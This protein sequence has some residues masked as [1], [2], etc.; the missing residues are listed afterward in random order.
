MS[1]RGPTGRLVLFLCLSAQGWEKK[2]RTRSGMSE[3]QVLVS[4]RTDY[5]KQLVAPLAVLYLA[6]LLSRTTMTSYLHTWEQK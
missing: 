5:A 2:K 1:R 4:V 3:R 6:L